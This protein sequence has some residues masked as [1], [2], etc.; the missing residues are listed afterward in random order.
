MLHY[1]DTTTRSRVR[2]FRV[3]DV[4]A[5][6]SANHNWAMACV[7]ATAAILVMILPIGAAE[8]LPFEPDPIAPAVAKIDEAIT[9][10]RV[11]TDEGA[12]VILVKSFDDT[13]VQGIPL[14]AFG[15]KGIVDPIDAGEQLLARTDLGNRLKDSQSTLTFPMSDVLSAAGDS[16]RNI[17]IGTNFP[18][19]QREVTIGDVFIFPK[20]GPASPPRTTVAVDTSKELLDYE[21]ELCTRFDRTLETLE[22]F[23]KAVKGF[24]LCADF[25]DRAELIR[26]IDLKN[27]TGGVGF[28]DAKSGP[29]Y[30]PTGPFLVIP[31]DWK[32]FIAKERITTHVGDVQ[33]QDARGGEMI[34]DHRALT[35][36]ALADSGKPTFRRAGQA[37]TL[38]DGRA[39][40]KG[41]IVMSGTA[42]GVIFRPPADDVVVEAIARAAKE[43]GDPQQYLAAMLVQQD[44]EVKNF[45]QPGETVNYRASHLGEIHIQVIAAQ[46]QGRQ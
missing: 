9:L 12:T 36:M 37:V 17:G 45:L 28:S 40:R 43:G 8:Q 4:D 7:A 6:L 31:R 15:I 29:D 26:N 2:A 14:L 34:L 13:T 5:P 19:H 10:A 32:S 35:G 23:D 25:T 11:K 24:F 20:F 21:V 33:R 27:P 18:E 1:W 22:D 30:F 42:E 38:M 41:A 44:K 3:D 46:E 16:S 39:V